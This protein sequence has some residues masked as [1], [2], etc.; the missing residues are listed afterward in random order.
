MVSFDQQKFAF[1]QCDRHPGSFG[2]SVI[3]YAAAVIGINIIF[4][5]LNVV[6]RDVLY[7]SGVAVS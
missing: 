4:Q 7:S 3:C 5:G 1:S 6:C 2:C